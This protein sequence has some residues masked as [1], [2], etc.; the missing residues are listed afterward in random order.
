M[1]RQEIYDEIERNK[2]EVKGQRGLHF[3][4]YAAQ[5]MSICF[6]PREG[7]QHT[8]V[9]LDE[10]IPKSNILSEDESL[11]EVTTRYFDA[12]GP[13]SVND[14]C[15]WTGLNLKEAARGIDMAGKALVKFSAGDQVYF[16]KDH[17]FKQS[18]ATSVSLLSWFD[19]FII[20]YKDRSAA[21]DPATKKFIQI[22]KNGLYT[23]VILVNGRIAGNWKRTFV[24]NKV[25]V[26]VKL[27]RKL[28]PVEKNKLDAE[29]ARFARFTEG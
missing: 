23:P 22:P 9:L 4:G 14:L 6:G 26:D 12:R 7:K 2:L 13:A 8:F 28:S 20:G 5:K 17:N 24:K 1:T 16:M 11:L 29:M 15:W 10:W 3:I 27:F 18:S 21:F 19:E 25:K